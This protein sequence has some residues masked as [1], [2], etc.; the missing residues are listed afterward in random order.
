MSNKVMTALGPISAD[1]LGVTLAHEHLMIGATGWNF[2]ATFTFDRAAA[3]DKMVKEINEA[4]KECGLQ[5]I[6]DASFADPAIDAEVYKI[7]QEK[8]GVNI[9]CS[10]GHNTEGGA[11]SAYWTD[12]ILYTGDYDGAL[13]RLYE[14]YMK[15][16]TVGI[17]KSDAKAGMLKLST[18]KDAMTKFEELTFEAGAMAQKETG[19]PIITHTTGSTLGPEQADYLISKGADPKKIAIGHM[20][21]TGDLNYVEEVL[22]KGVFI[23]MDRFGSDWLY[24]DRNKCEN[25]AK[26]IK[27][28][29]VDKMLL[30]HDYAIYFLGEPTMTGELLE[31]MPNWH[32]QGLLKV[33]VPIMK[34][35]GVTDEHVKTMLVDNPRRLFTGE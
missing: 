34:E 10:T 4:K 19:V 6:M 22:K 11:P 13:Q 27:M 35:F 24:P 5:T 18:S 33:F 7:V 28:G 2:D 14:S 8:T 9:I 30:G 26:L 12:A 3:V 29:Y 32:L 25:V 23:N 21:D 20:C 16:I 17:A 1:K 31:K 15:E